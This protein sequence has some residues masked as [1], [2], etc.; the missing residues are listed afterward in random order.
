MPDSNQSAAEHTSTKRP[1]SWP[2][3]MR[4]EFWRGRFVRG[5]LLV[6]LLVAVFVMAR[7]TAG[8]KDAGSSGAPDAEAGE[9]IKYWTCSMHPNI[10]LP[11]FGQCP[12]CF[13][14]L[15]SVRAG[16]E[17][18]GDVP[19]L[20]L[21]D[22][23]RKLA[24]VATTPVARREVVHEIHMVGKV[25][26]DETE[27][28]YIS[29]YIPG[30]LDRL[31]VDYTGILVRKGDHLAEI[32]SPEL[33]VTQ[34]EFLLALEGIERIGRSANA[35]DM[36]QAAAQS[37]LEAARRKLELWGIPRDEIERLA[38]DR[39]PSDH[40]RLDAP[41]EGWVVERQGYQGMYVET[42]TRLFTVVDLHRVWILL[43]AYEL[44]LEF[45]RHGQSVRFETESLPGAKFDGRISYI[46]PLLNETTRT[47]KVR[48]NV[49]NPELRLRPGMFVRGV[50]EARLDALGRPIG[51]EL[52]GKFICPMHPE[53]VKEVQAP[54]DK[55]GMDLVTAESMG[56]A[57]GKSP[58]AEALAVPASS[59]LLTGRRAIVYIETIKNDEPAYEGR[60]VELGPR[61]GDWY[62]VHSG[63]SPGERVVT[64]G[65]IQIDSA[66]QIQA[67]PSMM[68]AEEDAEGAGRPSG[69][70]S[71]ER[72]ESRAVAGAAYHQ[73]AK[74]IIS[75]Y[76]DMA[77]ALAADDI[78]KAR[79]AAAAMRSAARDAKPEGLT[80]ET[81]DRWS[82][83]MRELV[84]AVP[85]NPSIAIEPL[86]LKLPGVTRV[87]E[88]YLRTFG[89]DG[90]RKIYRTY[91]P[92]A[93]QDKGAY[94]FQAEPTI[95]NAYFGAK[96]LRCGE[97]KGIIEPDGKERGHE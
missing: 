58:D 43:D 19:R 62:V 14:D 17:S 86:R 13:M 94:W 84:L 74:P 48:L 82:S 22:R 2:P 15:I 65:A 49:E 54:C 80:G 3:D 35:G 33:L 44:D 1:A 24:R 28:T 34:R 29:S 88:T 5:C 30:R 55:C 70:G 16:S 76:L 46:D 56:Y 41:M 83:L 64:R 18:E 63:L 69:S 26:I 92:M 31:Y 90:G 68:Q 52:A 61:A 9:E 72:I 40:M 73:S 32:Y 45:L 42:G 67:K 71:L 50:V 23:A 51:G 10:Q 91:C 93:L 39:K 11:R 21:S 36:T 96:M 57:T 20:S 75:A 8:G 78:G 6:F 38:R 97:V 59:V 27:V 87:M 95:N 7:V 25:A 4:Y 77:A 89:H 81:A 85:D 37:V 60:V 66:M 53:I 47:V 12:V 79:T